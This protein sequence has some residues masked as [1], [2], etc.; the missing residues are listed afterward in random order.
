MAPE[1]SKAAENLSP[2]I[3][4]YAVDCDAEVNKQLCGE[5]V[6]AIV[7][8]SRFDASHSRWMLAQ[9]VQGFPTLKVFPRGG[10]APP[11]PYDSNERTSGHLIRWA[12][13]SVPNKVSS[14]PHIHNIPAWL[15][16][17][18]TLA[19]YHA[20][21]AHVTPRFSPHR[22]ATSLVSF[23]LTRTRSSP[24]SGRSLQIISGRSWRLAIIQTRMAR[25]RRRWGS[26][27]LSRERHRRSSCIQWD[28]AFRFCMKVCAFRIQLRLLDSNDSIPQGRQSM[29]P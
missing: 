26:L 24:Y 6:R 13:R 19:S 14:L 4:F 10:R 7:I 11:E 5:Q 20:S 29:S 1:Y 28:P 17:V 9:G 15:D 18:R 2:L 23:S 16:K 22:R 21:V 27:L 3:P 8:A 12:S 25:L